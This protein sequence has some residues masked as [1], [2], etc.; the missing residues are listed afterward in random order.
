MTFI[1]LS[2]GFLML[3]LFPSEFLRN[4]LFIIFLFS[5]VTARANTIS[6]TFEIPSEFGDQVSIRLQNMASENNAWADIQGNTFTADVTPGIYSVYVTP[7]GDWKDDIYQTIYVTRYKNLESEY[8]AYVAVDARNGDVSDVELSLAEP[9]LDTLKRLIRNSRPPEASQVNIGPTNNGG[10]ATISGAPGAAN[11]HATIHATNTQTGQFN[12]TASNADGSFELDMFAPAGTVIKLQQDLTGATAFSSKM[13]HAAG[14]MIR[15]PVTGEN[16]GAF[17]TMFPVK[18]G[19]GGGSVDSIA[20]SGFPDYGNIW[21]EG[22]LESQNWTAGGSGSLTGTAR[23]YSQNV[24]DTNMINVDIPV[25]A[26]LERVFDSSGNQEHANPEGL[27]FILTPSGLPIERR[28]SMDS[29]DIG[30]FRINEFSQLSEHSAESGWTF[31]YSVPADLPNGIYQLTFHINEWEVSS[32]ITDTLYYEDVFLAN[33]L[34][35]RYHSPGGVAPLITVGATPNRQLTWVLGLNDF[36]NGTSGVVANE[37]KDNINIANHVVTHSD[38]VIWAP[39]DE[40]DGTDHVYRLEPFVPLVSAANKGTM[41][42]PTIQFAFPSGS[43]NIQITEPDGTTSNLGSAPFTGS[44]F[45]EAPSVSGRSLTDSNTPTQY[46]GLTTGDDR[47]DLVFDQY[48]KHT[49]ILV[50]EIEDIFGVTYNASGT[51]EIYVARSLD[52]EFGVMPNTPFEVGDVFAPTLIIQPGVPAD[53]EI[54]VRQYPN[55]NLAQMQETVIVGSANDFGYFHASSTDGVLMANPGEYRVDIN[56]S[57]NDENGVLWMGSSTWGSIIE[58][59]NSPIITHGR[60]GFEGGSQELQQWPFLGDDDEV[61]PHL[62]FPFH[63]GDVVWMEDTLKEPRRIAHTLKI[64]LQDTAGD[65]DTILSTRVQNHNNLNNL[66]TSR[67]SRGEIPLF[68]STASTISPSLVPAAN[69]THWGY[70]YASA[71]RPG[72]RV[73]EMVSEDNTSNSYWRFDDPYREQLGVG[74]QG[75]RPND[76]KFQFG[77]AVYRAPDQNFYFYGAYASLFVL[78]PYDE[79]LGGRITP[80]FQGASGGPNGGPLFTLKGEEIDIFLH[81]TGVRPGS[82]LVLGDM[83]SFSGQVAP[84]LDS[85]VDITVT[86]PSGEQFIISGQANKIGYFYDPDA[87]LVASEVGV[88]TV[89]VDV[90]HDGMTSSG[91]AESPY[92][93][94]GVL[95]S[96]N[97]RYEF[98]V[99]SDLKE[100]IDVNLPASS[101]VK[102]AD[103]AFDISLVSPQDL[104]N[105][106]F[107]YTTTMPGFIL[108]QGEKSSVAYNYDSPGLAQDFPNLDQYDANSRAGVDTITMSFLLKGTNGN[109]NTEYRARQLLLQG[110]ELIALSAQTDTFEQPLKNTITTLG[111]KSNSSFT[112]GATSDGGLTSSNTFNTGDNV[113]ITGTAKPQPADIGEAAEIVVVLRSISNGSSSWTYLDTEGN[114]QTW[115]LSIKAL[116]PALTVSSL[117]ASESVTVFDGTLEAGSH[118]IYIGYMVTDGSAPLHFNS[119]PFV[120][121]VTD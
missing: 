43:L 87:V 99:V 16:E 44:Y 31:N 64:S 26:Y 30:N 71:T 3:S 121:D 4:L 70:F 113:L 69:D 68:S 98:Y 33:F 60:R 108:E 101:F 94:G 100:V 84:T 63:R 67:A 23:F 110:E 15:V 52:M 41:N 92:P 32:L 117:N 103:G 54:R 45:K 40:R 62:N 85:K 74:A 24:P 102:P 89:D 8:F 5:A 20:E 82:I 120:V 29:I 83:A 38:N 36:S 49:I 37:D 27:S 115:N 55:S 119:V 50:G 19:V 53:V 57:Y 111:T 9:G 22:S 107:Y 72:I 48:G 12:I 79:P 80:P 90:M 96:D 65:L 76:F 11:G 97:G 104:N 35:D 114:Y 109:G 59:P 47:F 10:I 95:G 105:V 42:P 91:P 51:Y 17:A 88:W 77:G 61:G 56:T 46:F 66:Y 106:V 73:R 118:R 39:F 86:S 14:T 21:L 93:E 81:P 13:T 112:A 25:Y 116:E 34:V 2:K 78:L 1:N 7:R 6:G 75:D 28:T 58:T 18:T